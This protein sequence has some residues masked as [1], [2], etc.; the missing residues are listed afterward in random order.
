MGNWERTLISLAET[1]L[2][3]IITRAREHKRHIKNLGFIALPPYGYWIKCVRR[4]GYPVKL[5]VFM[6]WF[7]SSPPPKKCLTAG[8]TPGQRDRDKKWKLDQER[9]RGAAKN[10]SA[11]CQGIPLV[12]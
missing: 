2:K 11:F 7:F 10:S 4:S 8:K 5:Q 1:G 6:P 9:D 3:A 12:S